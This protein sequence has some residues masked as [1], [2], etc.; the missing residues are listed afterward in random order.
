MEDAES[1][2]RKKNA[3]ASSHRAQSLS[4]GSPEKRRKFSSVALP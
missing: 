4:R 1:A 2:E 3:L